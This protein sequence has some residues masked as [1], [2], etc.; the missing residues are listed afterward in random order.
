MGVIWSR[1]RARLQAGETVLGHFEIP[2]SEEPLPGCLRWS[3]DNGAIIEFVDPQ[4]RKP[5]NTEGLTVHGLLEENDPI[6]LLDGIVKTTVLDDRVKRIG[7]FTLALGDHIEPGATWEKA[8]YASVNLAEWRGVTG[9]T[10]SL[11]DNPDGSYRYRLDWEPPP[12]Q[13]VSV[14]GARLKFVTDVERRVGLMPDY[15]LRSRQRVVVEARRPLRLQAFSRQY[16]MP[17]VALT[18]FAADRPDSIIEEEYIHRKRR[19][20]IEVWRAG[21]SMEPPEWRPNAL[22]FYAAS[23]PDFRLAIVRW[24]RLYERVRPALGIFGDYINDGS[25]FSPS[26]LITLH[27][28]ICGYTDARHS[29]RDPRKLRAFAHI[30]NEITGC[31]NDSLGLFGAA[32]DYFAHLGSPG[33][34]YSVDQ[35]EEGTLR[36]TRRAAALMQASLLRELGFTKR[37]ASDLLQR[38]YLSWPL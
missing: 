14:K 6:T 28:A 32:R 21:A 13:E 35:I 18:A 8:V 2:G 38:H 31:S 22:L 1:T 12:V 33:Q 3:P 34:K 11:P 26:R 37:R 19:Q 15:S 29:H 9:L 24:W 10:H 16:A 36:V 5:I 7:A 20:R 23:L 25:T 17:L 27:T 30:P 4:L